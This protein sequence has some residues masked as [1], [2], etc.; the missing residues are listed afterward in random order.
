MIDMAH[1]LAGP[2]GHMTS[3]KEIFHALVGERALGRDTKRWI[4]GKL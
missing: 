1:M 3:D 4:A 2:I